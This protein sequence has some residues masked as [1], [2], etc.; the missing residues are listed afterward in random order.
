MDLV[1]LFLYLIT[2]FLKHFFFVI[3]SRTDSTFS[4]NS[5]IILHKDYNNTNFK[6]FHWKVFEKQ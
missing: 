2:S 1:T 3:K 5:A 6:I 4:G